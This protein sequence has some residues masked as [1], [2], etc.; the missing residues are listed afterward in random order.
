M[1]ISHHDGFVNALA[2]ELWH[3]EEG[4]LKIEQVV[5]GAVSVSSK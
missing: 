4:S 3:V 2:K 5:R 1:T